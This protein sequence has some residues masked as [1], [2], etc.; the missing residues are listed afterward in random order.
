MIVQGVGFLDGQGR[1]CQILTSGEPATIAIRYEARQPVEDPVFGVAFFR[2]DGLHLSGANTHLSHV[3]L[4]TIEGRGEVRYTIPQLPFL[5]GSYFLTV[6]IHSRDETRVYDYQSLG[7][8]F[9]VRLGAVRERYGT[10]YVLARWEHLP[11]EISTAVE[12]PAGEGGT[13]G[14]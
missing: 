9:R 4:G 12:R 2:N 6:A 3:D 11:T 5:A 1:E 13:S 14:A 8:A 7:Y 10:V